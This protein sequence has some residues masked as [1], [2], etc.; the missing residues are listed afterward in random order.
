MILYHYCSNETFLSIIRTK[1][2][3]LSELSLSNDTTEGK[4]IRHVFDAMCELEDI[5]QNYKVRLLQE[6]DFMIN[7]FL[8]LGFCLSVVKDQLGQWRGYADNASG[9]SIGFDRD[10]IKKIAKSHNYSDPNNSPRPVMLIKV[11]YD[12]ETQKEKIRSEFDYI[13]HHVKEGAFRSTSGGLLFKPEKEEI[14]K[15]ERAKEGMFNAFSPM[16]FH[17]YEM[18]NPAFD[19]EREWRLMSIGPKKSIDKIS[20]YGYRGLEHRA[21]HQ[22]IVP[23]LPFQLG[24]DFTEAI[25]EIWLGPRNNT[26]EII[27]E[28]F[29]SDHEL[30]DVEVLS[31]RASFR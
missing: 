17:L 26:P 21:I 11:I 16:A 15:I 9:I 8:G 5:E 6:M 23:Y 27:V 19:E 2:V 24:V 30:S 1:S 7:H 25:K 4:W 20:P 22:Y 3:W 29:L 31:S 28:E 14:E 12:L 13:I 10:T 18:K